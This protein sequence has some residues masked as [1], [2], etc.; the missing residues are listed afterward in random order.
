MSR[1]GSPFID[2]SVP[3]S[4]WVL[5]V[6]ALDTGYETR[7]SLTRESARDP[8]TNPF[9]EPT[10]YALARGLGVAVD[11]MVLVSVLRELSPGHRVLLI[12]TARGED[13][14]ISVRYLGASARA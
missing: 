5:R 9:M 10:A 2:A 4:P 1:P 3:E 14:E 13:V 7:M 6:Y 12:A 11:D 8:D